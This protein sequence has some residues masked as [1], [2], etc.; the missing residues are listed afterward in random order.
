M[1]QLKYSIEVY[2]NYAL[3]YGKITIDL[4]EFLIQ[5]FKKEGFDYL[6]SNDANSAF[7]FVKKECKGCIENGRI[8]F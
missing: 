4:L 1:H 3:I 8:N 6:T 2:E 5:L 7:K